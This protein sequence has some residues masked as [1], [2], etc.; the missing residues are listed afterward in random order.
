M[1]VG[2]T[3]NILE[4]ISMGI[5]MFDTEMPTRKGLP[6][7]GVRTIL[8]DKEGNM[9]FGSRGGGLVRFNGKEMTDFS[10]YLSRG[11]C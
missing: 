3:S 2:T 5:D 7:S 4:C 10:F 8:Q 9:W 6:N 11:G 1:G